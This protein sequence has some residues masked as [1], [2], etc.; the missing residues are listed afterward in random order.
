VCHEV[1]PVVKPDAVVPQVR[2]DERGWE[3]E[4]MCHRA[5][6]RLYRL[7]AIFIIERIIIGSSDQ[8]IGYGKMDLIRSWE[9]CRYLWMDTK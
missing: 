8:T 2:F 3:T 7:K 6:P 9:G 4:L 1:K 5:C